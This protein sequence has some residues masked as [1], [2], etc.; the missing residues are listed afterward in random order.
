MFTNY[1]T[2]CL[3]LKVDHESG[4]IQAIKPSTFYTYLLFWTPW[5]SDMDVLVKDETRPSAH[6]NA[7]LKFILPPK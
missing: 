5:A 6:D 3:A 7:L 2:L 1:L 4:K